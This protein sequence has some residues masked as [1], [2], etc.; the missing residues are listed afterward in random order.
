MVRGQPGC[1]TFRPAS[2]IRCR[3]QCPWDE[4]LLLCHSEKFG[5]SRSLEKGVRYRK[6][7]RP[8]GCFAFSVPD[9]LFPANPK[10]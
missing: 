4:G 2:C 1:T 8:E 3:Q 7:E 9:P 10:S 5:F 6:P